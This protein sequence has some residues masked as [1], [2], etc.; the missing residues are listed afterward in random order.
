MVLHRIK[1]YDG[2][3]YLSFRNYSVP[4]EVEE[5]RQTLSNMRIE[6]RDKPITI[7]DDKDMAILHEICYTPKIKY[8]EIAKK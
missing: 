1:K 8:T 3:S 5:I 6:K 4:K 7:L 2:D